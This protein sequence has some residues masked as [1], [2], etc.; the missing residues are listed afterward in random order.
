MSLRRF[1]HYKSTSHLKGDH[2]MT[3]TTVIET[4]Y[5][6]IFAEGIGV[7]DNLVP[8][9]SNVTRLDMGANLTVV[10]QP[11]GTATINASGTGG[12]GGNTD[13]GHIL[14]ANSVTFTSSTGNSTTV[15]VATD[16]VAGMADR[17]TNSL[18]QS[19]LQTVSSDSSL[20]GAGTAASPLSVAVAVDLGT[21]YQ[22]TH[23]EVTNTRGSN[24]VINAVTDTAAGVMTPAMKSVLDTTLALNNLYPVL[25]N[26]LPAEYDPSSTY[27]KYSDDYVSYGVGDAARWYAVSE[28]G[29]TG[30]LPTDPTKWDIL[31]LEPVFFV[32]RMNT[33]AIAA[34]EN[35]NS[36]VA[37]WDYQPGITFHELDCVLFTD[38]II[39]RS[40]ENDNDD[41]PPSAK[42]DAISVDEDQ[43]VALRGSGAYPEL[44]ISQPYA[45]GSRLH[46]E[47]GN[48]IT[49]VITSAGQTPVTDPTLFRELSVQSLDLRVKAL[50]DT[51]IGTPVVDLSVTRDTTK[52]VVD[53]NTSGTSAELPFAT[54]TAAGILTASQLK[55]ATPKVINISVA[56]M[57]DDALND[58]A[59]VSTI[60]LTKAQLDNRSLV[61]V[62]VQSPPIA[63]DAGTPRTI[64][65][66][67]ITTETGCVGH[68]NLMV[69]YAGATTIPVE[70]DINSYGQTWNG[71]ILNGIGDHVTVTKVN[72][73]GTGNQWFLQGGAFEYL[74]GDEPQQYASSSHWTGGMNVDDALTDL[75]ARIGGGGSGRLAYGVAQTG[76]THGEPVSAAT[77]NQL[78]VS[79]LGI[80]MYIDDDGGSRA[81]TFYAGA[82]NGLGLY[83]G[84]GT[85]HA[86]TGTIKLVIPRDYSLDGLEISFIAASSSATGADQ[87]IKLYY[88]DPASGG[89]EIMP[90]GIDNRVWT[91]Q[92]KTREISWVCNRDDA[93]Y[94][95]DGIYI[96]ISKQYIRDITFTQGDLQARTQRLEDEHNV[97]YNDKGS[98]GVLADGSYI[99]AVLG[100]ISNK[101]NVH[102]INSAGRFVM[103]EVPS[104]IVDHT[105]QEAN[106]KG[107]LPQGGISLSDFVD[108]DL[109]PLNPPVAGV[110]VE[111]VAENGL[112]TGNFTGDSNFDYLNGAVYKQSGSATNNLLRIRLAG[113]TVGDEV[114]V[115]VDGL[116]ETAVTNPA[117]WFRPKEGFESNALEQVN[118]NRETAPTFGV[119]RSSPMKVSATDGI[120][121]V[122]IHGANAVAMKNTK[123]I[124]RQTLPDSIT[125]DPTALCS[126]NPPNNVEA[127]FKSVNPD[128]PIIR[129][130]DTSYDITD[131]PALNSI[132]VQ[133]AIEDLINIYGGAGNIGQTNSVGNADIVRANGVYTCTDST[134]RTPTAKG[135]LSHTNF[136]ETKMY[137][138]YQ[139][140]DDVSTSPRI[141][142]RRYEG[143]TWS[144]WGRVKVATGG[145]YYELVDGLNWIRLGSTP[146]GAAGN[147]QGTLTFSSRDGTRSTKGEIWLSTTARVTD[148]LGAPTVVLK[149][150]AFSGDNSAT[151]QAIRWVQENPTVGNEAIYPEIAILHDTSSSPQNQFLM[152]W[153]DDDSD[154]N[155]FTFDPQASSEVP[156][157]T[158]KVVRTIEV[159]KF[160]SFK[161]ND[162][163]LPKFAGSVTVNNGVVT[164]D[165]WTGTMPREDLQITV[166]TGSNFIDLDSAKSM[167]D[168]PR[169][170]VTS[171]NRSSTTILALQMYTTTFTQVRIAGKTLTNAVTDIDWGSGTHR[172]G[173]EIHF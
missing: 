145:G 9:A 76:L 140:A 14:N 97:I 22:L 121:F 138:R 147:I 11:D 8:I 26:E 5:N 7:L 136:S 55:S 20:S 154:L 32:S 99:A 58:G 80:P 172:F 6:A 24:T 78:L 132:S 120:V 61:Y 56:A 161:V 164:I 146:S 52:V 148:P 27:N 85:G 88:G 122:E 83:G 92:T 37:V 48:W 128:V 67:I 47:A 64:N 103:G 36:L 87:W 53:T 16:L 63:T 57:A 152:Q 153:E 84:D 60:T 155:N 133:S 91:D 89:E 95:N 158:D 98:V 40:K 96:Y 119:Y 42:W 110:Q 79:A 130:W 114:L 105:S 38:G 143:T 173:F 2:N 109:T 69:R 112:V 141:W 101:F 10:M 17:F 25:G 74:A 129:G 62:D 108:T 43:V 124:V 150:S 73:Y 54:E 125:P 171:L 102:G 71:A 23:V 77:T 160:D 46:F 165:N 115:E 35:D 34:L 127:C 94:P 131:T 30:I 166:G 169:L 170:S 68:I 29:V 144:D 50:E 44:D 4:Q 18:A 1:Q 167:G 49:N 134:V 66:I 33:E 117:F 104:V 126:V 59:G 107:G 113:V 135:V 31:G 137:Q 162:A 142:E 151:L 70:F 118:S 75:N 39:Y 12:G 65:K 157:G 13:L 168:F 90:I 15:P 116:T 149:S 86:D 51:P 123:V 21:I 139:N 111:L 41:V 3:C 28:D 81:A 100:D 82:N 72:N 19:A 163:A 159:S 156:S 93:I 45:E 106:L